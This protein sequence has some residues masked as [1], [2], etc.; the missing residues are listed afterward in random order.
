MMP[1]VSEAFSQLTLTH[2]Q[3]VLNDRLL[4][5]SFWNS[6]FLA[7]AG[8]TIGITLSTLSSYIIVRVKNRG[9][10]ILQP[11]AFT[12]F[13]FRGIVLAS[14]FMWVSVRTGSYV[15]LQALLLSFS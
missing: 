9:G 12:S 13:A 6:V 2:W 14:G 7:L 8:A 4:L 1:P 10:M 3:T 15:K 11:L 5:S